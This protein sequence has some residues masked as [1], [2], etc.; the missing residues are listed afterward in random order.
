MPLVS[1]IVPVYNCMPDLEKSLFSLCNQ[2]L[3]DIEIIVVDD[4]SLD[5]GGNFCD[6]AA[7]CDGRMKV[8]HQNNKGS[9]HARKAGTRLAKGKYVTFVDADDWIEPDLCFHLCETAEVR[10]ADLVIGAHFLDDSCGAKRQRSIFKPGYYDRAKLL[11]IVFPQMFHNDFYDGWGIYPFMCGKLFKREKLMPY[12]ERAQDGITLGDDVCITFP[13]LLACQSI[14]ILDKP[15]YHYVQHDESQSHGRMSHKD[16]KNIRSIYKSV[17]QSIYGQG[18]AEEYAERFRFYMLTTMLVPRFPWLLG[19]ELQKKKLLPFFQVPQ[20]SKV[21]IY[22]AGVLGRS[23]HDFLQES[24]F[25]KEVLWLD[26]RAEQLRKAGYAVNSLEEVRSW[27]AHDLVVIAII[28]KAIA[29]TVARELAAKGIAAE[30]IKVL[31]EEYVKSKE[32]WQLFE[33]EVAN[34]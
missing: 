8:L 26:A 14:A 4:G 23:F 17:K 34:E 12:M 7:V 28:N 9:I 20:G 13:Y 6:A 27:P 24:N 33:M 19:K 32:V 3:K 22:G 1:I 21:V 29:L 5:G 16:L 25:A 18:L 15:L 30:H 2:T 31:D 11:D 10:G